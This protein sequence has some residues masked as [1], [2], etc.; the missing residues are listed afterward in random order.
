MALDKR[1]CVIIHSN[2]DAACGFCV[3]RI[4]SYKQCRQLTLAHMG[5][6]E[7]TEILPQGGVELAERLVE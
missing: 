5:E 3:C 4:M 6:Y 2:D 1:A 7:G